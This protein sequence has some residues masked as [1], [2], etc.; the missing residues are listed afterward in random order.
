VR[1]LQEK[2]PP[3]RSLTAADLLAR[4]ADFFSIGTNDL[5]K[6]RSERRTRR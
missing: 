6:P 4:E 2:W 3:D 5:I 1:S